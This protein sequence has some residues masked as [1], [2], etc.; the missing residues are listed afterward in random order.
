MISKLS[1]NPTFTSQVRV[2]YDD[3]RDYKTFYNSANVKKQLDKLAKNG[4]KDT[5]TLMPS[6]GGG[7]N[8]GSNMKMQVLRNDGKNFVYNETLIWDSSS[9]AIINTYEK[10]Y[11]SESWKKVPSDV[12]VKKYL[13]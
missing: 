4:K 12:A 13:A 5:V 6:G 10:L 7:W 8:Q 1:M 3:D 11:E 2:I 9:N